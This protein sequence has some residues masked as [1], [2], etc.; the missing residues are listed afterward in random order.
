MIKREV[1][2]APD[3]ASLDLK[4]TREA[5]C[6]AQSSLLTHMQSGLDVNSVPYW[7]ASIGKLINLID[8]HRPLGPDGKHGNLHTSTCGCEDR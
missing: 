1:S 6:A 5:L 7:V 8:E 4:M 3:I 2:V